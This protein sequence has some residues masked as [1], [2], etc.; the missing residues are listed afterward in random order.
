MRTTTRRFQDDPFVNTYTIR[1]GPRVPLWVF[2]EYF[3]LENKDFIKKRE[4]SLNGF[5]AHEVWEAE[6][7]LPHD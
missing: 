5:L 2:R 4:A 1:F 3:L 7:I 6:K